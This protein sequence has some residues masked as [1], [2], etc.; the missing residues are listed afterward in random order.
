MSSHVNNTD[1]PQT[2]EQRPQSCR[3]ELEC[4]RHHHEDGPELHTWTQNYEVTDF[5][6]APA[7]DLVPL[8]N[9][10][11]IP[12]YLSDGDQQIQDML[13]EQYESVTQAA[14]ARL[15]E[16]CPL[17][18]QLHFLTLL[19][20]YFCLTHNV[21]GIALSLTEESH[22]L[23]STSLPDESH[24]RD[25]NPIKKPP[26]APLDGMNNYGHTS[27]SPNA[28]DEEYTN[29]SP[30]CTRLEDSP[31][32]P[33]SKQEVQ[34]TNTASCALKTQEGLSH[35]PIVTQTEYTNA[36]EQEDDL[37]FK[38]IAPN[39]PL[40]RALNE[41]DSTKA[42][43]KTPHVIEATHA[44]DTTRE[45][46]TLRASETT[47]TSGTK[48]N[49]PLNK[50][51]VLVAQRG[52]KPLRSDLTF[53]LN[54]S[55]P[56]YSHVS[57]T[58]KPDAN[59]SAPSLREPLHRP[60]EKPL[61][62]GLQKKDHPRTTKLSREITDGP[63]KAS[64]I[65]ACDADQ[66]LPAQPSLDHL[67]RNVRSCDAQTSAPDYR[68]QVQCNASSSLETVM[69]AMTVESQVHSQFNPDREEHSDFQRTQKRTESCHFNAHQI[70]EH[71]SPEFTSQDCDSRTTFTSAQDTPGPT[72]LPASRSTDSATAV[73]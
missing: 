51:T 22:D 73:H 40:M 6:E 32:R 7:T 13:V 29:T 63:V 56:R 25:P 72:E 12:E 44:Q 60:P 3:S 20:R 59:Q 5:K 61:K 49:D 53:N 68:S 38:P 33:P 62:Q 57:N 16:E 10:L 24:I 1:Y 64:N 28:R 69:T 46:P 65:H 35:A 41:R 48:S 19:K 34:K 71:P 54:I 42:S 21:D 37:V 9:A 2:D 45:D 27:P 15:L 50:Q 8:Y 17:E 11:T 18:L 14:F 26:K 39:K 31:N 55:N 67:I 52:A 23:K 30:I 43:I 36:P 4:A 58:R 70:T 66:E 47:W